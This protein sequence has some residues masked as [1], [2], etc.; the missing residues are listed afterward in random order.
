[1]VGTERKMQITINFTHPA[2]IHA[3][4]SAQLA[5]I[6]KSVN[7][8]LFLIRDNRKN[9]MKDI[10]QILCLGIM[11]GEVVIEATG[12]EAEKALELVK[13]AFAINFDQY[14]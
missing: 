4:P 14:D 1:M 3:R 7:A 5:T 13:A 2:G 11:P 12:P 8:E 10:L 9:D 6:A